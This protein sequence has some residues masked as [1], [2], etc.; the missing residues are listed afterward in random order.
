MRIL[1]ALLAITTAAPLIGATLPSHVN[2]KPEPAPA[3]QC[4][5]TARYLAEQAGNYRGQPLTP[6]KLTELPPA[7]TYMAVYRHIGECDDP[8]TMVEYRN[9]RR[10]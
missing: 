8:L 5:G 4:P 3:R 9:P 1:A 10:R 7:I 6:K 2:A